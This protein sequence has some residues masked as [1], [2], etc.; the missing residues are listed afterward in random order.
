MAGPTLGLW[1]IKAAYQYN[2]ARFM[3]LS[4]GLRGRVE[5]G[6]GC[7]VWASCLWFTGQGRAVFRPG[8]VVERGPFPLLLD[9]AQGAKLELGERTWVRGKYRAN[10]ITCLENAAVQI[11]PDSLLNGV[12]IS[13]REK[14]SIGK[15]AM[16]SWNTIFIDSNLHP[17]D[18]SEP[19]VPRPIAIGDYVMIGSGA[20][21]L[22]GVEIGSHTVVGAGSVV[23]KSLPD[24]VLAAGAPAKV[25]RKI[26]DRDRC[27]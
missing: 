7:D 11:G 26:G 4:R 2:R 1:T 13:A 23:T 14:I 15:K 22:A 3:W 9:L 5:F 8:C 6:A 19:L 20:M 21:V 27:L 18:N 10:V 17:L 25:I 24:H 12:I 16:L